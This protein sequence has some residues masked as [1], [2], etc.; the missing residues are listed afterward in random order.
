MWLPYTNYLYEKYDQQVH[1]QIRQL[2]AL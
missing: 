2:I 1:I